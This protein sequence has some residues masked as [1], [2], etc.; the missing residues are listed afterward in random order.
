MTEQPSGSSTIYHVPATA[1]DLLAPKPSSLIAEAANFQRAH[2]DELKPF[3][4]S[5]SGEAPSMH[6]SLMLDEAACAFKA[7]QIATEN[8][9]AFLGSIPTADFWRAMRFGYKRNTGVPMK[10][11]EAQYKQLRIEHRRQQ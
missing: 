2:W 1:A 8:G 4:Q 6:G 3:W 10:V 7:K 5:I 11:L 9:Y